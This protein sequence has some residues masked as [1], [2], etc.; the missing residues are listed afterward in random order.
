M[1]FTCVVV[2]EAHKSKKLNDKKKL[3]RHIEEGW[4]FLPDPL[5]PGPARP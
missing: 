1:T 2:L 3:K 4:Q 5:V